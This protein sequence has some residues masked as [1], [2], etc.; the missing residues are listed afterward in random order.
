MEIERHPLQPFLPANARLLML[1][2][3]PPA[4]KRWCMDFFYPNYGNDMWR[5]FGLVYFGD[6]N[7]FVDL[8]GKCFCREAIID[9]LKE[10]GIA[11]YDTACAVIRTKNTASDKDL[12][13]VETTDISAL[14]RQL[15]CCTALVT[16]GQKATDVLMVHFGLSQQPAVGGFVA[17][18]WDGRPMRFYRMPSSSRAYPLKLEEKAR[19]YSALQTVLT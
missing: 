10:E 11:L 17:F 16:T 19:K 1:G 3:F 13:V 14:L 6:K 12:E 8:E 2:S 5:I 7:H 15:P 4:R 9:F 18:Q